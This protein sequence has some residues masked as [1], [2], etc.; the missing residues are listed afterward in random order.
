MRAAAFEIDPKDRGSLG[1]AAVVGASVWTGTIAVCPTALG[2]PQTR[3]A[4]DLQRESYHGADG[5]GQRFELR[6]KN[7]DRAVEFRGQTAGS[8]RIALDRKLPCSPCP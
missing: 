8:V 5:A 6:E 3:P 7:C 1:A 2:F 4:A